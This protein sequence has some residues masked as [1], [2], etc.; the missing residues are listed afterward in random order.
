MGAAVDILNSHQALIKGPKRLV[1][2]NVE[3][4]DLRA[5]VTL[6]I[7]ALVAEGQSILHAAEQIDRGYEE[8]EGR[9]RQVGADIRREA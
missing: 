5:G 6:V 1:G 2:K 3:S 9:L 8:L 4:I 7:A